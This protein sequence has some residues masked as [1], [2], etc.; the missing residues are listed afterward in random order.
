MNNVSTAHIPLTL[1]THVSVLEGVLTFLQQHQ[2]RRA[3]APWE[4]VLVQLRPPMCG[5]GASK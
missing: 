1:I 4:A 5:A 2:L 3:P